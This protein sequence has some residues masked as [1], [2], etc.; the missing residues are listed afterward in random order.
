MFGKA[1]SRFSQFERAFR[2]GPRIG[3]PLSNRPD[4]PGWDAFA[5]RFSG[6][7][8]LS[9]AY[10]VHNAESAAAIEPTLRSTFPEFN[11]AC[12]AFDWLGRQLAIDLED[13]RALLYEPG[14]GEVLQ[15]PASIESLHNEVL[16][17]SPDAI[18]LGFFDE[19]RTAAGV[20]QI[21]RHQCVG[22]KHPL[23]LGGEDVVENLELTDL[24][25]YWEMSAQL[26]IATQ[27]LPVGASVS[28]VQIEQP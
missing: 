9:G 25:V 11:P 16:P 22:Y 21:A 15:T 26:I 27:D 1:K 18:A 13:R 17:S 14:A 20:D 10:R 4:V 3:E 6:S 2:P 19:W 5:D 28:G 7:T 24:G 12:F 23:Y 8:C